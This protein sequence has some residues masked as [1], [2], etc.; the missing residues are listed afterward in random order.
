MQHEGVHHDQVDV[1]H[2]QVVALV[3]DQLPDLAGRE[4]V[5]V[6]GAGTV[7]AIYRVGDDVAARFPLRGADPAEVLDQLRREMA[8]AAEFRRASPVPAPQ[9]LHIGQPGHGY[10]MPWTLQSWLPGN[11][12]TPTSCESSVTFANELAVLIAGLREWDT[13][14]RRFH[15]VGRGGELTIHDDWVD[16][17]I[18]RNADAFDV[19]AMRA[20]WADFRRLPCEDPDVMC[21]GDLTPSNL[22]VNGQHLVGVLDTGGFQPADPAL[23]LVCAW[24]LLSDEP[25]QQLRTSLGCTDLQW[26]RGKAWAFQQAAGLPWYYRDSNPTM[27]QLGT[28]TLHRLL[29][30]R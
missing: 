5:D 23:D 14:G 4:V 28:T 25:R 7:H 13:G 18:R 21:H 11:T 19:A 3:E 16:E 27:A 22:L 2:D 9:P 10:P 26:E 12:A 17:C 6:N 30:D 15:G 20:L 24:H 29:A 1:S 8:A